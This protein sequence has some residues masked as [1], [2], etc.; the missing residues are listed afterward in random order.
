MA[1]GWRKIPGKLLR[2]EV[3]CDGLEQPT[4]PT[5]PVHPL[6][7]LVLSLM[8]LERSRQGGKNPGNVPW[9]AGPELKC[10]NV[11]RVCWGKHSDV[12]FFIGK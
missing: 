9:T 2:G 11:L 5:V 6:T 1:G 4:D 12:F 10:A 8:L 3:A 7:D